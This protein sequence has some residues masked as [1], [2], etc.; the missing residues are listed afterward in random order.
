MKLIIFSDI[1]GNKYSYFQFLKKISKIEYD[2]VIFLGDVIG[3]YYSSNEIIDSM[4]QLNFISLLGNHDKYFLE[5]YKNPSKLDDLAKKYGNSYKIARRQ[6]SNTNLTY[7]RSLKKKLEIEAD[8]KKLFF[9]HG[10]P[11]DFLEGRIYPDTDLTI[12]DNFSLEY[13]YIFTGNTH[14]KLEKKHNKAT[15][16]NPGSLG[17][18]R[19]GAGCSFIYIDLNLSITRFDKVNYEIDEL[20]KEIDKYDKGNEKIKKVLRRKNI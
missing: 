6:I 20:E 2:K 17:Q 15:F 3:Y 10:S 14:Y 11:N 5:S 16:L 18:Q 7:L 9:C 4:R 8:G 12:F 13:D 1:H 19:D